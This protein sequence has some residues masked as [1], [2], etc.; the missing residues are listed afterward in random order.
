M[1]NRTPLLIALLAII[2]LAGV[3]YYTYQSGKPKYDWSDSWSDE[4]Y[5]ETNAE[6]YGTQIAHRLLEKY[7]PGKKLVDI[8]KSI[9]EELPLDS[10]GS[11]NYV[12]IG[13]AL[14]MDSLSTEHLGEFV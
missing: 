2:L 3:F 5:S 10:A 12:F 14:Y 13:E 11:S 7:F 6:P 4:A 8:Q 9:T 1:S